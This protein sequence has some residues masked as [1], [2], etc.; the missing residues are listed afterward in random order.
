MIRVN[1]EREMQGRVLECRR[2]LHFFR[3]FEIHAGADFNT[4]GTYLDGGRSDH[5]LLLTESL[6][7]FIALS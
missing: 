2:F 5:T 1:K 3:Q 7:G 6:G 4:L